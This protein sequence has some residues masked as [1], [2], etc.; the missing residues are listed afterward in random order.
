M[1][2]ADNVRA[3]YGGVVVGGSHEPE[4]AAAFLSWLAGPD[5]QAALAQFGFR[6]PA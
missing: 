4:R 6:P 2:E 3:T 5:G 1:P